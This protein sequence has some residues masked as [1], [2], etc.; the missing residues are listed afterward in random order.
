MA[1]RFR[2]I[3]TVAPDAP[4]TV[5][6]VPDAPEADEVSFRDLQAQA[7]AAGVS[8]KGSRDELEKRLAKVK[9]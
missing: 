1:R 2:K 4:V 9:P 3:A 8:A 6:P 5:E 7:K